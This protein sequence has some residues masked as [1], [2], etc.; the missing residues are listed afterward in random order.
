MVVQQSAA[1]FNQTSWMS[2][3]ERHYLYPASFLP[4]RYE[5]L[6]IAAERPSPPVFPLLAY[7]QMLQ[8]QE[9]LPLVT[10]PA[11]AVAWPRPHE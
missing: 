7:A 10:F 5:P 3:S 4:A 1:S 2:G 9:L 11:S 8:R 6:S